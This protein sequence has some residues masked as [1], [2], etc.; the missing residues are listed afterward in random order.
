MPQPGG[1]FLSAG[2]AQFTQAVLARVPRNANAFSLFTSHTVANGTGVAVDWFDL[3]PAA[4]SIRRS[5]RITGAFNSAITSDRRLNAPGSG[6]NM[7]L[8]YNTSGSAFF[9]RARA[10]SSINGAIGSSAQIDSSAG[11][12][13]D[14]TVGC[15]SSG[16][17]ICQWQGAS[18]APDP[19]SS[20]V[21]ASIQ[22]P[23]ATSATAGTNS[24]RAKLYAVIP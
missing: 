19:I 12:F 17:E 23:A 18:A 14:A 13:R 15:T 22:L 5:G 10:F 7:V 9:P 3:N 2:S 16:P 20:R 1:T 11:P 24:W 8:V 21:V 4:A 6:N